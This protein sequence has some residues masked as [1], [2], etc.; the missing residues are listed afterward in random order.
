[1]FIY[2]YIYIYTFPPSHSPTQLTKEIRIPCRRRHKACML[3]VHALPSHALASL[4]RG[5][6]VFNQRWELKNSNKQH[7]G[8]IRKDPTI[9]AMVKSRYIG[10]GHPTFN[11]ESL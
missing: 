6:E 3:Q 10:D 8:G 5:S 9:C 4:P 11:R 2:L 1:M 7:Q